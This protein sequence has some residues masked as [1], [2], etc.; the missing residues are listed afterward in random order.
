MH[1]IEYDLAYPE[2]TLSI[3]GQFFEEIVARSTDA[4]FAFCSDRRIRYANKAALELF[5]YDIDALL[6]EPIDVLIPE[7]VRSVHK[8]HMD[9]FE[10]SEHVSR[11]M[12]KKVQ[13]EGRR[14]DG[15]LISLDVSIMKHSD[16]SPI[17]FSAIC[18]DISRRAKIMDTLRVSEARLARAQELAHL[19]NWE[20][21][22]VTG[23]LVWSDEIY[24]IFGLE[25]QEFGASYEAF[26]DTVHV[27]DRQTVKDAVA[28]SIENRTPYE[29]THRIVCRD[30]TEK[31]VHEIGEVLYDD[32][33]KPWRMDGTVQDVTESFHR[34]EAL[35]EAQERAKDADRAKAQFLSAVSHELR[36]PLNAIIAPAELLSRNPDT[37]KIQEFTKM[38]TEGGHHLLSLVNTV[39]EVSAIESAAV[40]C[41]RSRF[42]S[43][44]LIEPALNLVRDKAETRNIS[45]ATDFNDAPETLY[46]DRVKCLQMLINLL[47]NAIA[48]S[49]EGGVISV[50]LR[51]SDSGVILTVED[52]GKGMTENELARCFELFSQ[53][54]MEDNRSHEGLGLGLAIVQRFTDLHGGEVMVDSSPGK[55]SIFSLYLPMA[56]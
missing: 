4:I 49:N 21:N 35:I 26:L 55:G 41:D 5:G 6:G 30:G 44:E 12:G 40:T 2:S 46:L 42:R 29:I 51:E 34:E 20:W 38:I 14:S 8:R 36:T 24:R 13:V 27:E 47:T 15:T 56:S 17:A 54:N 25:P 39:L 18:H 3:S 11:S 22:M 48:F 43:E 16:G 7:G 37:T 50:R 28:Y 45:I 31:I 1:E 9:S 10:Q 32:D 23:K 53:A 19:G 33:G 52:S